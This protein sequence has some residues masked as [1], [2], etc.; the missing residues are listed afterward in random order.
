VNLPVHVQ[1]RGVE[2]SQALSDSAKEYAHRLESF[3]P[4]IIAC[5][6]T[7]EL[8]QRHQHQGNPYEVG[9]DLTL[10]GRELVVSK[11]Q[12]ED[13]YVCLRDAF[14]RMKRQLEDAVR[15]RR[16]K[17]MPASRDCISRHLPD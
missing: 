16:R 12:N 9:I 6:I 11:V 4:N 14:D 10:P 17:G 5:R 15:R 2:P 8:E 3:A 13:A 7:I 1:F